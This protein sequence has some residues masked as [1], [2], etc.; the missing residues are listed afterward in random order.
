M[1][2]LML[3]TTIWVLKESIEQVTERNRGYEVA[4]YATEQIISTV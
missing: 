4:E 3:S 2:F 1:S